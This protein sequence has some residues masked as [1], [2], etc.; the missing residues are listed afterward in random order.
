[1]A[2]LIKPLLLLPLSLWVYSTFLHDLC[3]T[4]N[5]SH[6]AP[7]HSGYG[8]SRVRGGWWEVASE[9]SGVSAMHMFIFPYTDKAIM[10][11]CVVFGKSQIQLPSTRILGRKIKTDADLWA[12]AIEFDID[13][14]AIRPLKIV[15]TYYKQQYLF[16]CGTCNWEDFT[17]AHAGKRW[18]LLHTLD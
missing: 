3:H 6:T 10:F 12:H 17:G 4:Q 18:Y 8:G 5:S 16:G 11:G 15:F 9:N 13:S 1:M 14:A 7:I 2:C